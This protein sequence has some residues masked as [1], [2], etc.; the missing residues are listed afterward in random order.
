MDTLKA[1][2]PTA[3]PNPLVNHEINSGSFQ[4]KKKQQQNITQSTRLEK[5]IPECFPHG[6]VKYYFRK[7]LNVCTGML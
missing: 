5:K 4:L 7:L 6:K 2:F 3:D 1:C